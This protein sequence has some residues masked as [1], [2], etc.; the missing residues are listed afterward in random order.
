MLRQIKC[1][2]RIGNTGEIVPDR[3]ASPRYDPDYTQRIADESPFAIGEAARG[4]LVDGCLPPPRDG[5]EARFRATGTNPRTSS[6]SER[7]PDRGRQVD[8]HQFVDAL[9]QFDGAF[10]VGKAGQVNVEESAVQAR[11]LS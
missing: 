7:V 11:A 8:L 9:G 5:N 2:P 1:L 10:R 6:G 3:G 4:D